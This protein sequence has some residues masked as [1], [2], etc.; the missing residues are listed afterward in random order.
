MGRGIEE[1]LWGGYAIITF[2]TL[3]LGLSIFKFP[4]LISSIINL[5]FGLPFLKRWKANALQTGEEI[6]VASRE[7]RNENKRFWFKSFL[8]T[9]GSWSCR[10]LVINAIL[11]AFLPI[12]LFDNILIYGKQFVL[13]IF[14]LVSPTPGGSGVAEY[15]FSE[16]LD[17]F[18]SSAVLLV[19]LAIIW[20]LISYFPYLFIGAFLL[21]RW[22]KKTRT[23]K[24]A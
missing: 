21:P 13:W 14:M 3:L 15:A 20:R 7:L 16:L 2:L 18:S 11:N 5:V 8:S 17:P 10:Y 23:K 1:K 4:R 6:E 19:V 12:S 9:M 24:R 22:L